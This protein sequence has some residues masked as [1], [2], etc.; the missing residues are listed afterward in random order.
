MNNVALS[1][2]GL[3]WPFVF[4]SPCV[5]LEVASGVHTSIYSP[6]RYRRATLKQRLKLNRLLGAPPNL[7]SC[8]VL[9]LLVWQHVAPRSPLG[10][11]GQAF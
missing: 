10:V 4:S 6:D 8:Q 3:G 5:L 9:A 2:G 11:R 1:L 7:F